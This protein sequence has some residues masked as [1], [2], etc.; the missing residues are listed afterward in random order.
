MAES[1]HGKPNR[2]IR[3]KQLGTMATALLLKEGAYTPHTYTWH[4]LCKPIITVVNTPGK[5]VKHR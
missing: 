4:N 5:E 1:L 2:N 3:R